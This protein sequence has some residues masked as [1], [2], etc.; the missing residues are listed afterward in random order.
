MN[1]NKNKFG[2][3]F[4]LLSVFITLI[5]YWSGAYDSLEKQLYDFRF[6]LRGPLSG[7]YIKDSDK[8]KKLS[9][10]NDYVNDNDIVII[11][12]DQASYENIGRFYPYDRG[13][14]WSKVVKNL[15]DAGVSVIAFDIMFDNPTSSDTLFSN[16]IRYA[17]NK[18]VKVILAANNKIETGIGGQNFRL[19]K[20]SHDIINQTDIKLGLVGTIADNDGFVRRYITVDTTIA[21]NY[22]KIYYSLAVQTVSSFL[23]KEPKITSEGIK[24]DN[25]FIPHYNNQNT[26][27]LNYF[28][29]NS[30]S[31]ASTF[32]KVPLHD[33]LD[34][35]SCYPEEG[36]CDPILKNHD[37]LDQYM[38]TFIWDVWTENNGVN[39]FKGKIAIIGSALE[40]HHD[41]FN[42]PFNTFNNSG[43]M[44]G[45][46]LHANAIQQIIDNN[47][48]ESFLEFEGYHTSFSDKLT[49]LL[50]VLL[51]SFLTFFII[52]YFKPLTSALLSFLIIFIWFDISIGAFLNDY[53]WIFKS[54][55]GGNINVPD[56][57]EST[58]I[59]VI[60]PISS[61][62]FSY[63]FN[64]SF[65]V[66]M[67]QKDKRFFKETFGQYISPDLINQM[68]KT[69]SK[70]TLGG[71]LGTRTAFFTDIKGFSSI[72]E[73]L[74]A[75]QLVELLNEYLSEMTD[76]LLKNKGTLDKYEG[77]AIL[78]MFGAPITM[79]NHAEKAIETSV[80]MQNKL[81]ELRVKW[82]KTDKWPESVHEMFMRIGISSGEF[83]VGNMGSTLRM[84][85]TM[86]GDV[87]NT[88]ARLE[89]AAKIYGIGNCCDMKTF[90][91]VNSNK[92]VYRY[93][94]KVFLMGKAEPI[95]IIEVIDFKNNLDNSDN[96]LEMIKYF[97]KGMDYY[98]ASNWKDAIEEFKQSN[99]LE[100]NQ[101]SNPSITF[102]KR[103]QNFINNP[104]SNWQGIF[105]LESK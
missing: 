26:F 78:A 90:K 30:Y 54:I 102:I 81:K 10:K 12:I 25:L 93:I 28:G 34:D 60:Y 100:L 105:K 41:V 46:E 76:I 84:D 15:V 80:E 2:Y 55:F 16:S 59:P 27:L 29:P 73:Q 92:Y 43:D 88:A 31:G 49:S 17:N 44:F 68:Y 47:H 38:E 96:I 45:V 23:D 56:I 87:V 99:K 21:D 40:E 97:N 48:I 18:G 50:I 86:M 58:I 61:V 11:G 67:E 22:Q 95:E 104:P 62:I 1:F 57:G 42:T 33:I 71:D 89:S 3:I 35:G 52:T 37:S 66:F 103:C 32:N 51:V 9:F 53:L 72:S 77:D 98:N 75:T 64:L 91:L 83:V 7:D 74:S 65:K 4:T 36:D 6:Q 94:D 39:P 24:I 20:P 63:A 85:Y 13:L 8:N 101:D 69:Q 79:D 14:I 19:I 5:L 82:S 70:P